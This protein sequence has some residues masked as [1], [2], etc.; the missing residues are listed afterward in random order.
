MVPFPC[1]HTQ[2]K[3]NLVYFWGC[4]LG[5][6]NSSKLFQASTL[7]V[8]ILIYPNRGGFFFPPNCL[9]ADKDVRL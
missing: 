6:P 3:S 9:A 2:M 5:L 8:D 4:S 1:L 7:R